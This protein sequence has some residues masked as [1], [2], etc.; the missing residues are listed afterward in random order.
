MEP[1][2]ASDIEELS[3]SEC[4]GLL[5]TVPIGRI[6]LHNDDEIEV[7]PVNHLVDGGTIVFRTATGTKLTLIGQ[8][9]TCTFEADE[10]DVAEQ[11]VWSV[12]AKGTAEQLRGHEQ[13]TS[14]FDM[15]V[16]TWQAG[17]KPTYVRMTPTVIS[18]RRFPVSAD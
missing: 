14:S 4:W 18:G 1:K 7:F 12:V 13:I 11:L 17:P 3:T 16:P 8:D 15:E 10:V 9:P 2:S 6:A 5:R